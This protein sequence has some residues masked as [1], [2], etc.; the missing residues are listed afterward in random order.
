MIVIDAEKL[1]PG[2]NR[3]YRRIA[4]RKL[5]RTINREF[6]HQALLEVIEKP[7]AL[8]DSSKYRYKHFLFITDSVYIY[9]F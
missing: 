9:Y 3:I 7:E 6:H 8:S 5:H 4:R 2:V 1:A